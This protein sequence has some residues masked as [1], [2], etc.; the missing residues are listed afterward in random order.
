MCTNKP[1]KL[2]IKILKN[3]NILKYFDK[4]VAGGDIAETKPNSKYL[5]II[6]KFF[7]VKY[8]DMVLIGDSTIDQKL[9]EKCNVD[10]FQFTPGYNDGINKKKVKSFL[11]NHKDILKEITTK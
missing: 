6:K 1:R 10:F 11:Q 5:K 8:K 3:K 2:T 4:I 9:A 7:N